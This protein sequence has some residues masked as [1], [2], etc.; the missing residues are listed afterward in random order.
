MIEGNLRPVH[1]PVWAFLCPERAAI[2]PIH[3]GASQQD[4]TP[5]HD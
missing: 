2:S 4:D 1:T 3:W 5:N